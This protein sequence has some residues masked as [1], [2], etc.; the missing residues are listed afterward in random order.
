MRRRK[1]AVVQAAHH[2]TPVFIAKAEGAV[3]E[4][5]GADRGDHSRS[6]EAAG[7]AEFPRIGDH[8]GQP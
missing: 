3:V 7:L 2:A 6:A 8:P 4:D 5:V 1:A